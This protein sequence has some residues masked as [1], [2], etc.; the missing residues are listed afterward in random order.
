MWSGGGGVSSGNLNTSARIVKEDGR[1]DPA[2]RMMQDKYQVHV[3]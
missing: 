3:N 1:T 2:V